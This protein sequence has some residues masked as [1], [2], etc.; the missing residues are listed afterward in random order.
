RALARAESGHLELLYVSPERLGQRRTRER[1]RGLRIARLAVDEA[2]CVSEWGHEF[3]PSYLVV[4]GARRALGMPP[5]AAFTATATAATRRDLETLLSIARPVRVVAPVDREN[6]RWRVERVGRLGAAFA[7]VVESL[8]R[9]TGPA[10]VY[11]PTRAL[12]A[13]AAIG[14]SRHGFSAAA[15][16]AG[17]PIARRSETQRRFLDDEIRVV[18]A[19]SAFGMGID[20]PH[21]RLVAHLGAPR[22]TEQYVQEAG[23]AGRDGQPSDCLLVS[24]KRRDRPLGSRLREIR[25]RLREGGECGDGRGRVRR[26]A[27]RR[28]VNT[29]A[30]RRAAIAAYFGERPP[31]CA[32][33]DNCHAGVRYP[34]DRRLSS[35]WYPRTGRR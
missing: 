27:M 34:T 15:Y 5:L 3:R 7:L 19:T 24:V 33:C 14:L 12:S 4:G 32:G 26:R 22:S 11:T 1:L 30:C 2:H 29:R 31:A 20:H 23:R 28:Y 18:C 35:S 6:L 8:A 9:S 13:R 25:R 17:L 10:I 21:V 16:H